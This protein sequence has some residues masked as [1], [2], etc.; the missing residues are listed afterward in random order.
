MIGAHA[1][2][3]NTGS[4]GVAVIGDFGSTGI[5]SAARAALVSL[6]AWRLD[7][8]HVDPLSSVVRVSSGNP[9]YA[10]GRAVTLRAV[11]GHRDVYP[12]SCPG[13]SL[14]A[15]LPSIRD[16]VAQSGL[17][18]LYSPAV[19]GTLG[20]PVRFTARL[21]DRIAW[22]VTV[23]NQ[24][25]AVVASGAG[26]GTNVDGPGTPARRPRASTRGRSVLLRCAR[27]RERSAPRLRRLPYS[28]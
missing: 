14:Y 27:L 13:Q 4:V 11:S 23:R 7:L 17:P 25:K 10:S 5:T 15:Q 20:A 19:T 12:T 24:S 22:V 26:I 18:K 9:R 1:Q 6:I 21:S 2:G 3:F 8:D 16:A 28:S